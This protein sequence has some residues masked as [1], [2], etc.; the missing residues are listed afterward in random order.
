MSR[1][2]QLVS[3]F[4]D[5]V[6][7]GKAALSPTVRRIAFEGGDAGTDTAA[8][9]AKVRAHAYRVTDED[10]A[11]LRASG[12]NDETLYEVTIA[13]AVGEGL[14]RLDIGLAALAAAQARRPEAKK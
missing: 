11:A 14:R 6:L 12:W 9:L 1:Y 3:A 7:H 13:T 4:R 2:A 10:V 5:A 8:Y